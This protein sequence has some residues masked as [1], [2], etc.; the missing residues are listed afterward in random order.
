MTAKNEAISTVRCSVV[1]SS[2]ARWLGRPLAWA[3]VLASCLAVLSV[4]HLFADTSDPASGATDADRKL[5]LDTIKSLSE[6]NRTHNLRLYVNGTSR[7]NVVTLKGNVPSVEVAREAVDWVRRVPGILEVRNELEI[8]KDL[9]LPLQ[10]PPPRPAPARGNLTGRADNPEPLRKLTP[11][12]NKADV[13]LGGPSP[14][15]IE[16]DPTPPPLNEAV[17]LLPPIPLSD[18]TSVPAPP[19][20][21]VAVQT[22]ALPLSLTQTLEQLRKKDERFRG[23]EFRVEDGRVSLRST[24]ASVDY[25]YEFAQLVSVVPGV[26]SVR[27]VNR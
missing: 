7:Q 25:L 6:F 16:G 2:R 5:T 9:P 1:V 15:A 13:A 23:I 21:A 19:P 18:A 22:P 10:L 27:I 14:L 3:L 4:S 17:K 26:Q 20:P 12:P 24:T 11:S 8:Q